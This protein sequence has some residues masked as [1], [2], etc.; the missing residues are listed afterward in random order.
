MGFEAAWVATER[1]LLREAG[2]LGELLERLRGHV[3]PLL[4]GGAGWERLV[5]R[6]RDLPPTFA[7]LPFGFE[8][9]LSEA[10]ADA[11][12]GVALVDGSRSAAR[13]EK[14]VAAASADPTTARVVRFL[15]EKR[16]D[17]SPVARVIGP[18]LMLEYDVGTAA[19]GARQDPGVFLY[20][21][22]GALAGG[23]AHGS[24]R[25]LG[26]ILDA[27]AMLTGWDLE[28]ERRQIERV[29]RALEPDERVMSV[30]AFPSREKGIRF[31]VAGFER[32]AAVVAFLER[33][34]RSRGLPAIASV[35]SRLEDRAAF[36]RL[37]V[38]LDVR[39]G[40]VGPKLG[41]GVVSRNMDAILD[42][43][44][45]LDTPSGWSA[46]ADVM[47]EDGLAVADKLSALAEWASG[48]RLL[49]GRS[50]AFVLVRGVHHAKL[51]VAGDRIQQVKAYV[52]LLLCS[53]PPAGDPR[54]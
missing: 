28:A 26:V 12:L 42:G 7:S 19:A 3:S 4:V 9:P 51:L 30:G 18:K 5:H 1:R 20:P 24:R 50:G 44:Y 17:G 37:T 29:Y 11:D 21:V 13:F 25:N 22:K 15:A 36:A 14:R 43:R 54:G 49:F 6:A 48:A 33:I 8:L 27:M 40:A 38:H 39:A 2:S 45:W 32:A 46:F 35:L 47:R 10:R 52:F 23:P 53:Y 31:S 34:G 41:V 16:R